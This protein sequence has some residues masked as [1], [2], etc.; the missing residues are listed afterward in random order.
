MWELPPLKAL[1]AFES[2][3][4]HMS[5]VDAAQ[6]LNVTPSAISRQIKLIE[7]YFGVPL[8]ERGHREVALTPESARYVKV[9]SGVFELIDES[10]RQL[11][12]AGR[13]MSM[14]VSL[15]PTLLGWLVPRLANRPGD[16]PNFTVNFSTAA[17][18]AGHVTNSVFYDVS[19]QA[20]RN[21]DWPD[22]M[23]VDFL[24]KSYLT[25][26]CTQQLADAMLGDGNLQQLR[27]VALLRSK[28]R[29]AAWSTW[30]EAMGEKAAS[31][32]RYQEFPNSTLAFQAASCG[33]GVAIGDPALLGDELKSGALV[34]PF[35]KV[36]DSGVSYFAI[37]SRESLERRQVRSFRRWIQQECTPLRELRATEPAEAGS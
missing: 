11:R 26:V 19:I 2:A 24:F 7:D 15:P 4:R 18:L 31:A 36:V 8:F 1:K 32:Y 20:R 17:Y 12:Q 9:I 16:P 5:F 23:V 13:N 30:L 6:E 27:R 3:A 33:L 28:F 34:M 21:E 35:D 22:D 25:P 10:S 37:Y 14:T 29:M